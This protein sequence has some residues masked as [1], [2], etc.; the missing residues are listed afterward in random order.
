MKEN[1][2]ESSR[3]IRNVFAL[4]FVSFFTDISSEMIFSLLPTFILEL[5]GSNRAILGLIEGVSEALSYGLRAV[6]GFFSDKFRKRKL[7]VL[8]GYAFSNVVKP[9]FA[10]AQSA[11]DALIIRVADRVGKA[12]RTA[13][14]DALLS[15]SIS[16][17]RRGTAFGLHRTLDQA[18]AIIG[19]LVASALLL[20][21][22]LTVR[23]VFWISFIPGS[24]AL[25]IL[26]F[27]VQEH[28]GKTTEK[29]KLLTGV[30]TVLKGSFSLLLVVV[31]VFSLGAFNFSFILLNAKEAGISDPLIPLVYA[32]V[33][34]AHTVIAIPAGV[35]SDKIGKE[36]VLLTGYGIFLV[37]SLLILLS[38]KIEVYAYIIALIFGIYIG[39]IE[40]IQRALIP[41]YAESSLRG[42][43]Y[44]LYYLVVGIAFFIANTVVG[45]LWQYFGSSTVAA[46]SMALSFIAIIG[47]LFLFNYQK[48]KFSEAKTQ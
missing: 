36:R 25:L 35:L 33:N 13:P 42:T 27:L 39:I 38:P 6:S 48:R 37:T 11:T 3:P 31:A 16:E 17:K 19:P 10:V 15:E 34:V 29:F 1:D 30:R 47:M 12:V 22:G 14:R 24:I 46:Y 2:T 4:G 20:L 9:L 32:V 8:A 5:P 23:T 45:A 21:L 43:A 18:G 28:I 7:V 44:G 41:K 26:L 40:T